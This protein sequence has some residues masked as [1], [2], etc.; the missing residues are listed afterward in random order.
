MGAIIGPMFGPI[1]KYAMAFP[2]CFGGTTS[3]TVPAPREITE[4]EA[5]AWKILKTKGQ[6]Y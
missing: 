1:M 2:L 4:L 5:K 3:V 6:Q